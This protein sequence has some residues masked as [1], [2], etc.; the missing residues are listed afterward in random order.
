MRRRPHW[1]L[2]A[3]RTACIVRAR[4][5]PYKGAMPRA[6][7]RQANGLILMRQP[8]QGPMFWTFVPDA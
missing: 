8:F 5:H 1:W 2:H 7:P 3:C 6:A 4:P